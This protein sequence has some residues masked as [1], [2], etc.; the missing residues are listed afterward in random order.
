MDRFWRPI[1]PVWKT[2]AWCLFNYWSLSN[3]LLYLH[4]SRFNLISI[5]SIFMINLILFSSLILLRFLR[6]RIFLIFHWSRYPVP[7]VVEIHRFR[8]ITEFSFVFLILPKFNK[9]TVPKSYTEWT[10]LLFRQFH[11]FLINVFWCIFLVLLM[12]LLDYL[13]NLIDER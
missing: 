4:L 3:I 1:W 2:I 12:V 9:I 10:P 5:Q 8:A 7:N 6:V 11:T 13:Y